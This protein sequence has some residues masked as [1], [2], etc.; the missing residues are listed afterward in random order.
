MASLSRL[1]PQLVG[2]QPQKT[3]SEEAESTSR[4][5]GS[6][7]ETVTLR[8]RSSREGSRCDRDPTIPTPAA[9]REK[10]SPEGKGAAQPHSRS[11]CAG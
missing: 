5:E 8:H 2:R 9:A 4:R 11:P 7:M 1:A 3:P 10:R 6:A